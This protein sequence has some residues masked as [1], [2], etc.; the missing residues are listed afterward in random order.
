MN[1]YFGLLVC[2]VLISTMGGCAKRSECAEMRQFIDREVNWLGAPQQSDMSRKAQ[3]ANWRWRAERARERA[4]E[5]RA[6][7]MSVAVLKERQVELST[8]YDTLAK[9][10]DLVAKAFDA[11]DT[12]AMNT[13][14]AAFDDARS[15][16]A[17][18]LRERI[19]QSCR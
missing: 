14:S 2:G 15:Q 3:A 10:A 8:H 17:D 5:A 1:R 13:H 18:A 6:L 4:T 19:E 16:P 11:G 9:E 12:N 7:K